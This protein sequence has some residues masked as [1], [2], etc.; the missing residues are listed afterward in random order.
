MYKLILS[1]SIKVKLGM[2]K[3]VFKNIVSFAYLLRIY[4]LHI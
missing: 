4:V 2:K 3:I 1:D